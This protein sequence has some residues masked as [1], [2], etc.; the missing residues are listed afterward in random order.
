MKTLVAKIARLLTRPADETARLGDWSSTFAKTLLTSAIL[1]SLFGFFVPFFLDEVESW[2]AGRPTVM[3]ENV[4]WRTFYPDSSPENFCHALA[5]ENPK[6]PANPANPDLWTSP[7]NRASASHDDRVK[8]M[9][10]EF[11]WVGTDIGPDTLKKAED[12]QAYHL[13]LGRINTAY[14]IWIDGELIKAAQQPDPSL[15]VIVDLPAS[16]F[17][18]SKPI[19]VA[20]EI[21]QDQPGTRPDELGG[22]EGEG[23]ATSE[24][25]RNYWSRTLFWQNSGPWLF[26][27]LHLVVGLFFVGFWMTSRKKQEYAYLALFA[28]TGSL[29]H[30]LHIDMIFSKLGPQLLGSITEW[31]S[32]YHASFGLFLG[33]AFARTRR[34]LFTFGIPIALVAP[35]IL[36]PLIGKRTFVSIEAALFGLAAL[37]CLLQASWLHTEKRHLPHLPVRI[38]RLAYFGLGL[39]GFALVQIWTKGEGA[40]SSFLEFGC[41]I[42]I[43]ALMFKEYREAEKFFQRAPVSEFHRRPELPARLEGILMAVGIKGSGSLYLHGAKRGDSGKLMQICLSHFSTAA[44]TE[45]GVVLTTEEDKIMLFF[46]KETVANPLQSALKVVERLAVEL[47][48]LEKSFVDQSFIPLRIGLGFRVALFTAAL[49]PV[50]LQKTDERFAGW[51]SLAGNTDII[52]EARNTLKLETE[53][54]RSS[55]DRVTLVARHELWKS[56]AH[57]LES[58]GITWETSAEADKDGVKLGVYQ[59]PEAAV[60]VF[61]S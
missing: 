52:S 35:V 30:V 15:P 16:K 32:F 13:L 26:F 28:L 24:Q 44:L 54:S 5:A 31:F 25:V 1:G 41:L 58:S 40:G 34:S 3:L 57:E 2:E 22:L 36:T 56:S 53:H 18:G 20:M 51:L 42:F 37:V 19:R 27:G 39:A 9:R 8:K 17:Q 10:N 14:R 33:L 48:I 21:F 11:F 49:K 29:V 47:P 7:T 45:S 60:R 55:R 6:C 12:I 50:W 38:R 23:L 43:S 59:R 4:H 61:K 46:P